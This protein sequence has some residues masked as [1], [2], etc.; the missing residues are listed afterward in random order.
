MTAAIVYPLLTTA[1]YYLLA[2]AKIS[3]FLW[4]RYP[5]TL[6]RFMA[7]ASC[8]GFWYG[9][10][11]ATAGWFY[12]IPFLA[13]PPREPHTVLV[14][15]MCSIV[16]TPVVAWLHLEALERL[17]DPTSDEPEEQVNTHAFETKP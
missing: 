4:S 2:R 15:G 13:M 3:K 12:S 7:C 10:A 11:V 14:V 9:L 8:T 6:D 5:P 16:W 17:G 1:L